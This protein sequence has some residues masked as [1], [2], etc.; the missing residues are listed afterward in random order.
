MPTP[1]PQLETGAP[2]ADRGGELQVVASRQSTLTHI[3]EVIRYQELLR[4]LVRKELTVRYK[5][6]VLGIAWSM[7]NPLVLLVVYSVAFSILGQAFNRFPIWLL[8]GL[9]PWTFV[10][11]SLLQATSSITANSYLVNKVRFP[12]EIL[13]LTAVGSN[14]VN[15]AIQLGV[16]GVVIAVMRH[17]VD[18]AYLWLLPLA[19]VTMVVF[20]TAV[21][22]LLATANV[23]ARDTQHL[24]EVVL[25]AFFWLTPIAY[26]VMLMMNKLVAWGR[27]PSLVLLNPLTSIVTTFQRCI[28][29]TDAIPDP[30][31]PGGVYQLLPDVSQWWYLRNL[32][33]VLTASL[34]LLV[35]AI[36]VIDKAEGS[37]AELM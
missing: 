15:L 10:S 11:G 17:R 25:I 13:P 9:L 8:S 12:R 16:F 22:M 2:A 27:S 36:R 5:R 1:D 37:F 29:G 21:S 6:S 26:P 14:L 32:L 30:S 20:V 34:V 23:Y 19:L 28:Y 33:I 24:L 4:Q 7:L 3:R 18:W 35:V 31:K